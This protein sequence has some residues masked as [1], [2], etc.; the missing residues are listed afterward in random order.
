MAAAGRRPGA[1]GP[2]PPPGEQGRLGAAVGPRTQARS[3][4]GRPDGRRGCRVKRPARGSGLWGG[5][6]DA[7][8][9]VFRPSLGE[10]RRK[11]KPVFFSRALGGSLSLVSRDGQRPGGQRP[12]VRGL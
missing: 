9:P 3:A 1:W 7:R 6:E 8:V 11:L 5:G 2:G 10:D 12:G 4:C